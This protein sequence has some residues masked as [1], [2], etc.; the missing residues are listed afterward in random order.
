[1]PKA[2]VNYEQWDNN[3]ET[4]KNWDS[5]PEEFFY[6]DDYIQIHQKNFLSLPTVGIQSVQL[7]EDVQRVQEWVKENNLPGGW[8]KWNKILGDSFIQ[9][10]KMP[11]KKRKHYFGIYKNSM[12][13][14]IRNGLKKINKVKMMNN[15]LIKYLEANIS[16]TFYTL[17]ENN[18]KIDKY[19]DETIDNIKR[20]EKRLKKQRTGYYTFLYPHILELRK[21]LKSEGFID[22]KLQLEIIEKLFYEFDVTEYGKHKQTFYEIILQMNNVKLQKNYRISHHFIL[23]IGSCF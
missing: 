8:S 5:E 14:K 2:K 11:N 17:L 16:H 13:A 6:R 12:E 4:P 22:D 10:M 18:R 9:L 19:L 7:L 21:T 1:M 20:F 23:N 3:T 15:Q